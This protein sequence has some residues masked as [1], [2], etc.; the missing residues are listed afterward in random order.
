M[1]SLLEHTDRDMMDKKLFDHA[2]CTDIPVYIRHI[3]MVD[4]IPMEVVSIAMHLRNQTVLLQV[5]LV[6]EGDL[7]D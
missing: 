2:L 5:V 3:R 1:K 6:C 7:D 4:R